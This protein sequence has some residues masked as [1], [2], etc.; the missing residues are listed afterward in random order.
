M[1]HCL[2]NT[3]SL[4]YAKVVSNKQAIRLYCRHCLC[5]CN[6]LCV[7]FLGNKNTDL[8]FK[9]PEVHAPIQTHD[10]R[11]MFLSTG[12]SS[13][14]KL[15]RIKANIS[16]ANPQLGSA[17]PTACRRCGVSLPANA[18]YCFSQMRCFAFRKCGVSLS[19]N[20]VFRLPRLRSLA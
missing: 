9:P 8:C 6:I 18:E 17:C 4:L 1:L 15:I 13:W 5:Y 12:L 20:A 3:V 16:Q 14:I 11:Y 10:L 2:T 7:L 19:A